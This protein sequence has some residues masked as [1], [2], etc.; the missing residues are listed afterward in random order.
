MVV[1]FFTALAFARKRAPYFGLTP[2][3]VSDVSFWIIFLGILGARLAFILQEWKVYAAK[4]SELLTLQFQ[5]LT[6]FGALIVGGITAVVIC[7][8]KKV[9]LIAFLDTV[10]P[11]FLIGNAIGRVGCLLNGCCHGAPATHAFPF[12]AY[13]SENHQYNVPAQLY[14]SF[15]NLI[16]FGILMVLAKK[17]TR[18][19]FAFGFAMVGFG[20]SRFIYEFWR[21]GTSSTTMGGTWITEAQIVALA[22]ALFGIFLIFRPQKPVVAPL[23]DDPANLG[24]SPGASA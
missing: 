11:A 18:P 15:M 6:S 12:L 5:G 14:E 7:R 3:Q 16:F 21:A 23:L 13:S 10:G 4:P 22:V 2:D 9:P 17:I 19:G 24:N 1:S 20:V 8:K